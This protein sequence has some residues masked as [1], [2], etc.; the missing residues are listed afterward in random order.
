[1]S[2]W[3]IYWTKVSPFVI[4]SAFFFVLLFFSFSNRSCRLCPVY[5]SYP[6]CLVSSTFL[7]PIVTLG[8]DL[9]WHCL[10]MSP[11]VD[12]FLQ[13]LLLINF[14]IF[15]SAFLLQ[16][17]S[18]Y[19]TFLSH[20]FRSSPYSS[21]LLKTFIHSLTS[22]V[23]PTTLFNVTWHCSRAPKF[24]HCHDTKPKWFN[25]MRSQPGRS[26]YPILWFHCFMTCHSKST[27]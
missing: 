24:F 6:L 9:I 7:C 18:S 22:K 14:K 3:L 13:L 23:P 4:L 25:L 20:S 8:C 10:S 1:M 15:V 26:F 21:S 5:F 11:S 2:L 17:S 16:F 27:T 19:S 12:T